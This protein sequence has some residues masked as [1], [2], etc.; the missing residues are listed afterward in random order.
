MYARSSIAA[1]AALFTML[2]LVPSV[3]ADQVFHTQQIELMPVNGAPLRS[4]FVVDIH[5][6]GPRIAALERY[7]LS[8]AA[9][10]TTYQVQLQLYGNATCSGGAVAVPIP[11]ASLSTNTSGNAQASWTFLPSDIP[12]SLHNTTIYLVWQVLTGGGVAY[13]TSCIA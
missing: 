12:E 7:V 8:G 10:N 2:I 13:Q 6:N 1:V 11:T 4:G 9:P 3:G 5:A